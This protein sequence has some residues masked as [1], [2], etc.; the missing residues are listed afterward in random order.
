MSTIQISQRNAL[1]LVAYD[2]ST[3]KQPNDRFDANRVCVFAKKLIKREFTIYTAGP[4]KHILRTNG[5]PA[6]YIPF[7]NLKALSKI[8]VI[9]VAWCREG[10]DKYSA[11]VAATGREFRDRLFLVSK[12][13][14]DYWLDNYDSNSLDVTVQ[15]FCYQDFIGQFQNAVMICD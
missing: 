4:T 9:Y 15:Q 14:G 13:R 6:T 10:F 2:A 7:E 12:Q 8:S 3:N 1:V 11:V 5:I